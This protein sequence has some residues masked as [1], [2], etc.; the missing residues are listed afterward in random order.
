MTAAAG[1]I[2]RVFPAMYS[3]ARRSLYPALLKLLVVLHGRGEVFL[4]VLEQIGA[5]APLCIHSL[6]L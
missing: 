4:P 1:Q 2:V 6:L 3:V 5:S